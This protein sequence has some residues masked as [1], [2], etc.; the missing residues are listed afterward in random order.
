MA[1][2]VAHGE[3]PRSPQTGPY[4]KARQRL[5]VGVLERLTRRSAQALEARVE[6]T[7]LF[8][9][10]PVR[11]VDGTTVTMPDTKENRQVFPRNPAQKPGCGFPIA[12]PVAVISL[13]T[14]AVL[15]LAIGP[16]RGK[17]SGETASF[18]LRWG[19]LAQ[20]D[21]VPGDR[22]SSSFLGIAPLIARG[23]DGL[24]RMHQCRTVDSRRGRRIGVLDHVVF[25]PKPA[26]PAWMDQASCDR[27][28]ARIAVRELRYEVERVGFRVAEL[29]LVTTLLDPVAFTKDDLAESYRRRWDVELDLRSIKVALGMDVL[30]RRTPEMVREEIW[31]HLLASNLV[32]S[33]MATAA[34][35]A[36]VSPR[37]PSFQGALQ[38][39]RAFDP[40][41]RWTGPCRRRVMHKCRIDTIA[42]H[43]V[44]DRPGRSEPRAIKRRPRPHKLLTT[45]RDKARKALQEQK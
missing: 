38:T 9:G 1:A 20:G 44:G 36:A 18:R 26:R 17:E 23:V 30:R 19:S 39:I 45:T 21:I 10:R 13:A 24:F 4:C 31:G 42:R 6:D 14:G 22:Y 11:L 33:A 37:R 3:A 35:Q 40:L 7:W 29:V 25:W 43:R 8:K 28:P 12:R 5:P 41:S 32:R 34:R 2:L 16:Y 15:D 27:L